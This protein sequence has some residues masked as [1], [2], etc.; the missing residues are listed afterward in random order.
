MWRV[1]LSGAVLFPSLFIIL[2]KTLPLVFRR[3]SD[4]DVVLVSER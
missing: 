2:R 1:L 3:W 4:A